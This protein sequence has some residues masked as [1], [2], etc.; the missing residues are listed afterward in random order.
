MS[1]V[2]VRF[3]RDFSE[4]QN[5]LESNLI[6][7]EHVGKKMGFRRSTLLQYGSRTP[8]EQSSLEQL[9]FASP[10]MAL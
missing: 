7:T 4:D 5:F 9:H 6:T 8:P 10:E 3:S 2:R 1:S